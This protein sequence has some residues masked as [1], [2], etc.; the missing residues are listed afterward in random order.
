MSCIGMYQAWKLS[1]CED[2]GEAMPPMPCP[3]HAPPMSG[4]G[5]S[6]RMDTSWQIP[7]RVPT[8]PHTTWS[9]HDCISRARLEAS[10]VSRN[11]QWKNTE[12]KAKYQWPSVPACFCGSSKSGNHRQYNWHVSGIL[13]SMFNTEI[14]G[15]WD[16]EIHATEIL[17]PRWPRV[18]QWTQQRDCLTGGFR[19]L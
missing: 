12:P 4:S 14:L 1:R 19:G 2:H 18:V 3:C 9:G 6:W 16:S 5:G 10:Q 17:G 15:F 7:T 8:A 11:G 13:R